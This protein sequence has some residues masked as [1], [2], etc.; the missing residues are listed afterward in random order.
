M[1]DTKITKSINM[2]NASRSKR[3]KMEEIQDSIV[4][5]QALTFSE[6]SELHGSILT[7]W[8]SPEIGLEYGRIALRL[9]ML[10]LDRSTRDNIAT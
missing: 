8:N 7:S 1:H 2:K 6:K 9:C 4:W 3:T 10:L 5:S